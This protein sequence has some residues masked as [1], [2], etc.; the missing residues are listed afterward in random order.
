M[1]HLL[2]LLVAL[3][4]L[5]AAPLV[6]SGRRLPRA[7]AETVGC[8]VSAGTA[9]LESSYEITGT[10]EEPETRHRLKHVP[11]TMTSVPALLLAAS[12]AVGVAPGF[13]E[14]VGHGVSEAGSGGA[15]T[16]PHWTLAGVLLGLASTAL[17]LGLAALA[18]TRPTP[19]GE[20][21]WTGPLRRLQSGHIG[22]YVA[23]MLVGAM[24]PGALALPGILGG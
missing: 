14:V 17:A 19:L 5:G 6:A 11:D 24:L 2:P 8:V 7:V 22:D 16:S 9:G 21:P 3:P 13:A 23:W 4:L 12:L 15:T 18:V 20:R 10:G 1:N